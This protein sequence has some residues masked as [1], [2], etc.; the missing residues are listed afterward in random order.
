MASFRCCCGR[1]VGGGVLVPELTCMGTASGATGRIKCAG[2]RTRYCQCC[3]DHVVSGLRR[4]CGADARV[5]PGR[6]VGVLPSAAVGLPETMNEDDLNQAESDDMQTNVARHVHCPK[7][8]AHVQL[9][10]RSK[11]VLAWS[12]SSTTLP[13]P[14]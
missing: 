3:H 7:F 5:L 8:C 6:H 1:D 9:Q 2:L 10:T 11:A 13:S 12:V 14:L 4:C